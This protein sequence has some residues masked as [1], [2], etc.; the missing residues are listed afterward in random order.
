[1]AYQY[2]NSKFLIVQPPIPQ[3]NIGW[4]I[5]VLSPND[6]A[7]QLA[8]I[9]D[10][11]SISLSKTVGGPGSGSA[12]I[13][14]DAPVLRNPLS[15]GTPGKL[16]DHE[17]LWQF[18]EGGVL[19][20]EWLGQDT[21]EE[22]VAEGQDRIVTVTGKTVETVLSWG[23]MVP[24]RFSEDEDGN[25]EYE[26]EVFEGVPAIEAVIWLLEHVQSRGVIPFVSW[27]FDD[28]T[29][30]YGDEW[31]DRSEVVISGGQTPLEL[32]EQCTQSLGWEFYMAPNF[33]L[34]VG[35][36]GVGTRRAHQVKAFIGGHQRTHTKNS[37]SSSIATG[38]YAAASDGT[39]AFAAGASDATPHRREVWI[40]AGSAQTISGA[41]VVANA[42]IAQDKDRKIGRTVGLVGDRPGQ[43]VFVDFGP[44][45]W[46]LIEDDEYASHEVK[47]VGVS[48]QV[49]PG[50]PPAYEVQIQTKFDA[51]S[52]RLARALERLG[53]STSGGGSAGSPVK[54]LSKAN[55]LKLRDLSD[56]DAGSIGSGEALAWDGT[57]FVPMVLPD[58]TLAGLTDVDI[59]AP[60]NGQVLTYESSS[61][62]WKPKTS[63]GG[64]GGAF[65]SPADLPR[66]NDVVFDEF[67]TISGDWT[68]VNAGAGIYYQVGD[69]GLET[70]IGRD[71]TVL[72]PLV[73]S[74][75]VGDFQVEMAIHEIFPRAGGYS[76]IN[77]SIYNAAN[78]AAVGITAFHTEELGALFRLSRHAYSPL[79]RR[80]TA[81]DI[82][83]VRAPLYL[84][85][86]VTGSNY[87]VGWS[88]TGQ[89]WKW[90]TA[91]AI[92]FTPE[93]AGVS[94][95]DRPANAGS[96]GGVDGLVK[97][98]RISQ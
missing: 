69:F 21:N 55:L 77:L 50:A 3:E 93:N 38:A 37:T 6:W 98:F 97:W 35:Q 58:G 72:R 44:G 7:T 4:E 8:I 81:A 57:A 75:P 46:I 19:R 49:S 66:P 26:D 10:F 20:H 53:A 11:N 82:E 86:R 56:V 41:A 83:L 91:V 85:V 60:A 87:Q 65:Y 96:P 40:E 5:R 16:L 29:D 67:S 47:I 90:T 74:V 80:N 84:A 62:L 17:S 45:D 25:R 42:T 89:L 23:V 39:I 27:T 24:E 13:P 15:A 12:S 63:A 1:M 76:G 70:G 2:S 33:R 18:Y 94:S 64:G 51:M 88:L 30:S 9:T 36:K 43:R 73:R 32:L 34:M 71:A 78:T 61:G 22:L 28:E 52:V 14:A 95:Y 31:E 79:S 68:Q 48:A 59:Q 54:V 92:G